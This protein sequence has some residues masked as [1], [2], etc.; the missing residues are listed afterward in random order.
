MAVKVG[1]LSQKE[2]MSRWNVSRGTLHNY[3]KKPD[4]PG[5][6]ADIEWLDKYVAYARSNSGRKKQANTDNRTPNTQYQTPNTQ[7]QTPNTHIATFDDESNVDETTQLLDA[8]GLDREAKLTFIEKNKAMTFQYQQKAIAEYRQAAQQQLF[9]AF[10]SLYDEL[11][12]CELTTA[13]L[14]NVRKAIA[15]VQQRILMGKSRV[16]E[17][18]PELLLEE[19]APADEK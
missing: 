3:R 2:C 17:Q 12:A 5:D 13:Q 14:A 7:Y 4:W 11:Q 9:K 16:E 15:R 10:D 19:A 8:M 6:S 18:Q 1:G